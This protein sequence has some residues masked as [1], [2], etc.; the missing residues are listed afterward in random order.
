MMFIFWKKGGEM[1]LN[2]MEIYVF[3][4]NHSHCCFG[5]ATLVLLG[6]L[7]EMQSKAET[8]PP[9]SK[10][11]FKEMPRCIECLLQFEKPC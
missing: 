11:A 2:K 6:N 1:F 5:P 4:N 3:K 9:K 10:S 7:L 8:S